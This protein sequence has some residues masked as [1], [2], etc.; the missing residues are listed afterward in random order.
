MSEVRAMSRLYDVS[1]SIADEYTREMRRLRQSTRHFQP[2]RPTPSPP[3]TQ[4]DIF[5]FLAHDALDMK[6]HYGVQKDVLYYNSLFRVW[7]TTQEL[8]QHLIPP[9]DCA[10]HT[11]SNVLPIYDLQQNDDTSYTFM[12]NAAKHYTLSGLAILLSFLYHGQGAALLQRLESSMKHLQKKCDT[13]LT[14]TGQRYVMTM[15]ILNAV[16]ASLPV[17]VAYGDAPWEWTRFLFMQK[18]I[19]HLENMTALDT[20]YRRNMVQD[21][22]RHTMFTETQE[23]STG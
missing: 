22:L 2:P 4:D 11:V 23:H 18:V 12:G 16:R 1:M 17:G 6:A 21:A 5:G 10:P 15:H 7:H 20:V 8:L 13:P 19:E 3:Y 9:L 14:V